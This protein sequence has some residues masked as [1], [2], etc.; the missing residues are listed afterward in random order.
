M[1]RDA[2]RAPVVAPEVAL[3]QLVARLLLKTDPQAVLDR[4]Q[5]QRVDERSKEF[6]PSPEPGRGVLG[7]CYAAAAERDDKGEG[8]RA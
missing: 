5:L 2:Q 3:Q 1:A 6:M 4:Q 8:N 7:R